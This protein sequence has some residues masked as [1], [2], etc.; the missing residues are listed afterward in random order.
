MIADKLIEYIQ[1][2]E[3]NYINYEFKSDLHSQPN[4]CH[5]NCEEYKKHNPKVKLIHGWLEETLPDGT[6]KYQL[7]SCIK[8][9]LGTLI[10]I[11]EW[12]AKARKGRFAPDEN[13][14]FNDKNKFEFEFSSKMFGRL[15]L[16]IVVE[17]FTSSV[18]M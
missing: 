1:L 4:M 15:P 7:H 6:K 3:F 12:K 2:L 11:T 18:K 13:I 8:N 17:E 16:T 10:D 14:F 5:Q 9:E